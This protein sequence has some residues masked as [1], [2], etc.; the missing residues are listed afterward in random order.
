MSRPRVSHRRSCAVTTL[1]PTDPATR[2]RTPEGVGDRG[3]WNLVTSHPGG[4][5]GAGRGVGC[6]TTHVFDLADRAR[7][8]GASVCGR[9][10]VE[11]RLP[12]RGATATVT[13]GRRGPRAGCGVW[14]KRS[15][16][17]TLGSTVLSSFLVGS[18]NPPSFSLYCLLPPS[19]LSTR[20]VPT[21]LCLVFAL[22]RSLPSTPL[23]S[24]SSMSPSTS[25][26]PRYFFLF[27]IPSLSFPF[28]P[29]LSL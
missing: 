10:T 26:L 23:A 13:E 2:H 4:R 28:T 3:G 8:P 19:P 9:A 24:L 12:R 18:P 16:R 6:T 1:G 21:P 17:D 25:L 14:R 22:L 27:L 29:P 7:G 5:R 11:C 15:P 20:L